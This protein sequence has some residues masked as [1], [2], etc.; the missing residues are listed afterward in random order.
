[1]DA[2]F[3]SFKFVFF[4]WKDLAAF[5]CL[6]HEWSARQEAKYFLNIVFV[7][8]VLIYCYLKIRI[9][10]DHH[11]EEYDPFFDYV[12]SIGYPSFII[13]LVIVITWIKPTMEIVL[14]RM[15]CQIAFVD[16]FVIRLVWKCYKLKDRIMSIIR[17]SA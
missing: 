5:H 6:R 13:I 4:T 2:A 12:T 14:P 8:I 9:F 3:F 15:I 17:T 16:F 1:M 7:G 11:E 10:I